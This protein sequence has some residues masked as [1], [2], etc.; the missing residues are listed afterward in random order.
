MNFQKLQQELRFKAVRSSGKG[1]QN[2]NKVATKV[3]LYFDIIASEQITE[4][5]KWLILERL[6]HRISKEGVLRLTN[7]ESR[8]QVTNKQLCIK[9]LKNLLHK[10]TRP[11]KQRKK[12]NVPASSHRRRLKKKRQQAEKKSNR[13]KVVLQKYD[14]FFFSKCA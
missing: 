1:G 14:L 12:Q 4:D 9:Q 6:S 8:S 13:K 5:E 7:Q 3:E 2:V 11:V 10:A